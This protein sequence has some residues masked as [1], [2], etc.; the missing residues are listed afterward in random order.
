MGRKV[1]SRDSIQQKSIANHVNADI[2][3]STPLNEPRKSI[4]ILYKI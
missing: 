1:E 2:A 3:K 4:V